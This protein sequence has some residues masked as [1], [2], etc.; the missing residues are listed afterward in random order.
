M[1]LY[2]ICLVLVILIG[3]C[4]LKMIEY[5]YCAFIR[6]QP[7]MV[8]SR[9]AMRDAVSNVIRTDY[10]NA[11]TV[12]EIGAGWGGMVRFIARHT[13]TTVT[14]IENMPL[15]A[16]MARGLNLFCPRART[17]WADAF[18]YLAAGHKFDIGVAYLGPRLTPRLME[19][20][21]NFRVLISCDFE[22]PDLRP[23][24]VIDLGRG[25]VLYRGKKYPHKLFV[26]EF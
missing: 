21:K 22:I 2:V 14:G 8:P 18:G 24:C 23:T 5:A 10:P 12:C 4:Y 3:G 7:P 20:S 25:Y 26:Y 17:I 16:L 15:S 9:H 13:K 1:L 11:K 19:Y 6:H